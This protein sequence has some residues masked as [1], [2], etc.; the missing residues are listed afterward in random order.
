MNQGD[1]KGLLQE[2][3]DNWEDLKEGKELATEKELK[4]EDQLEEIVHNEGIR[5][6]C[7]SKLV[8]NDVSAHL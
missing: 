4:M 6:K 1:K 5:E 7:D 2:L 8:H 3:E